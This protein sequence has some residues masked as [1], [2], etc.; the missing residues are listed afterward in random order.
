MS[1][2]VAPR[3]PNRRETVAVRP[4]GCPGAATGGCMMALAIRSFVAALA[5][6]LAAAP[7]LAAE[8]EDVTPPTVELTSP[9]AGKVGARFVV[10]AEAADD[11]AVERVEFWY[12][13]ED[14]CALL[15]EDDAA[16]YAR[17]VRGTK[18]RYEIYAV[19]VDA[20]GNRGESD[21]AEIAVGRGSG[22]GGR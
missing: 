21:R 19:A 13:E 9:E 20:A 16:P 5:A 2:W 10:S 14:G 4:A 8:P 1:G 18:G 17:P 6:L 7:V 12:C 15:A 22:P 3:G 11:V